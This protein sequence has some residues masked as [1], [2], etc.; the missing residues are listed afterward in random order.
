MHCFNLPH[1]PKSKPTN[2]CIRVSSERILL[3]Q[4]IPLR[5]HFLEFLEKQSLQFLPPWIAKENFEP[6]NSVH[7][8]GQPFLGSIMPCENVSCSGP[9]QKD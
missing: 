9:L 4:A 2:M 8:Q 5:Q 3:P 6:V 7:A 1:T